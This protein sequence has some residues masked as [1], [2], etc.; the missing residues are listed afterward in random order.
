[1]IQSAPMTLWQL[2]RAWWTGDVGTAPLGPVAAERRERPRGHACH[3]RRVVLAD[4]T[5]RVYHDRCNADDL[6]Q[7]LPDEAVVVTQTV[8]YV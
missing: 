5:V 3:V 1:M 7:P 6:G 4:G 2:L 8:H